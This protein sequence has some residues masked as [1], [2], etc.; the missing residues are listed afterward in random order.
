MVLLISL[1]GFGEGGVFSWQAVKSATSCLASSLPHSFITDWFTLA[2]VR[3]QK[4]PRKALT[5]IE[6]H[7]LKSFSILLPDAQ[8]FKWGCDNKRKQKG[9]DCPPAC[10]RLFL[11]D[12][13]SPCLSAV[14][15]SISLAI[16]LNLKVQKLQQPAQ[17][18][19]HDHPV[20]LGARSDA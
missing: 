8:S 9:K 17:C 14:R 19:E 13:H 15:T 20:R 3:T 5:E 1:N 2:T 7:P 18:L 11:S 16:S 6:N 10:A 4:I 12:L